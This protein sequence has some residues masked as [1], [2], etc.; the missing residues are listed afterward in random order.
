M[1]RPFDSP[2]KRVWIWT[3]LGRSA[4]NAEI[5]HIDVARPETSADQRLLAWI[6]LSARRFEF[7]GPIPCSDEKIPCSAKLIPCSNA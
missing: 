2:D 4:M 3:G 6:V 1:A 7:S 5:N